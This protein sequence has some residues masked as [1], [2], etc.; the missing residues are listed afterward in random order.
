MSL[1]L[2][3]SLSGPR[4]CI[5]RSL[6]PATAL[7]R[8]NIQGAALNKAVAG[9]RERNKE[10]MWIPGFAR[11]KQSSG[12][13]KLRSSDGA[14]SREERLLQCLQKG[15]KTIWSDLKNTAVL[16]GVLCNHVVISATMSLLLGTPNCRRE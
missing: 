5:R 2:I 9:P 16:H 13:R 10:A 8:D 7:Q 1:A 6:L 15:E 4:T 3:L 11:K 14:I 12:R